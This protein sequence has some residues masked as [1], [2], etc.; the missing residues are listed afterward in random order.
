MERDLLCSLCRLMFESENFSHGIK[1]TCYH[2]LSACL[3][4]P[5]TVSLL[6]KSMCSY[7]LAVYVSCKLL[8]Y[9]YSAFSAIRIGKPIRSNLNWSGGLLS[10]AKS[11]LPD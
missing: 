5:V 4:Y 1:T 10:A 7:V 11:G 6:A 2:Y 3:C 8:A 9:T